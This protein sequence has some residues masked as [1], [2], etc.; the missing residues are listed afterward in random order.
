M[1][2]R[3]RG[4]LHLPWYPYHRQRPVREPTSRK[5]DYF[6]LHDQ[7]HHFVQADSPVIMRSE[8]QFIDGAHENILH[9]PLNPTS[10]YVIQSPST[11]WEIIS[12]STVFK[13][14]EN[15]KSVK[16]ERLWVSADE[17]SFLGSVAVANLADEKSV[18]CRFTFDHWETISE[19]HAQYAHGLPST[20]TKNEFDRF[21][22]TLELLD[23]ALVQSGIKTFHCCIRYIANGQEFWD[24]NNSLDYQV[25]FRRK[26][27]SKN[28]KAT[29]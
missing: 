16:L 14:A 19:V 26:E 10:L 4:R 3:L 29:L 28:G 23:V 5:A 1:L 6:E 17:K 18:T 7:E 22:F 24:N 9:K 12:S 20:N 15:P 25:S 8:P 13:T 11:R 21:L 2:S 27:P